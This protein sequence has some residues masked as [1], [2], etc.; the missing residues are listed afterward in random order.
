MLTRLAQNPEDAE[1]RAAFQI[2][3]LAE[4]LQEILYYCTDDHTLPRETEKAAN[5]CYRV[6]KNFTTWFRGAGE[7]SLCYEPTDGKFHRKDPK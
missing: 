6:L 5:R 2:L 3:E 7:H 1:K 4:G